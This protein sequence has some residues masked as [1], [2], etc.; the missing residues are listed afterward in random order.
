[1]SNLR[2]NFYRKYYTLW[3][4]EP[5]W[6]KLEFL[7]YQKVGLLRGREMGSQ[8]MHAVASITHVSS[9]FLGFLYL[10][11]FFLFLFLLC[12]L[13]FLSTS[14]FCL[15]SFLPH[16][17]FTPMAFYIAYCDR[18]YHFYPLTIFGSLWVSF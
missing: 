7:A 14:L 16:S 9:L 15:P 13:F 8:L 3:K 2:R 11:F 18:I 17:L 5:N 10:S 6:L 4:K 1:M 12:F